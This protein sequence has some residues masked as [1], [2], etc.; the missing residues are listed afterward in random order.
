MGEEANTQERSPFVSAPFLIAALMVVALVVALVWVVAD[1]DQGGDQASPGV[2][3]SATVESTTQAT[4]TGTGGTSESGQ[5]GVGSVCG[6]AAGDQAVPSAAIPTTPLSIAQGLSVPSFEGVGPGVTTGVT[7]CFAHSPTGALL[8]GANFMKW[9]SSKHD[10]TEVVTTLMASGADRDRLEAQIK[11]QWG[12]ETGSAVD[13]KGYR[14]EDR[15]PDN[16]LVVL[17]VSTTAYPDSMV[18]WPLSM[19]WEDG[20]WK[21]VAPTVD[22]W[23]ERAIQSLQLEG[24]VEWGA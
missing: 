5:A 3:A 22:D 21:V 4:P 8:A 13:I 19:T 18:A 17:A 9:F 24:F 12:G 14:F 10:L 23:G 15:G 6:L 16:A 7:H 11:S 2:S 20:D 1:R